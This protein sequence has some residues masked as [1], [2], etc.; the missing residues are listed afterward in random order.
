MIPRICRLERRNRGL[1]LS[2]SGNRGKQM[3][4]RTLVQLSKIENHSQVTRACIVMDDRSYAF[5]YE[6]HMSTSFTSKDSE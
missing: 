1:L 3:D 4:R 6:L 5:S 2:N